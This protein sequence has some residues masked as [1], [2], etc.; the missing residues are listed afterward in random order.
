MP[1]DISHPFALRTVVGGHCATSR[2][3]SSN[4]SP[5]ARLAHTAAVDLNRLYYEL[6]EQRPG[7]FAT[8][9]RR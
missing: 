7:T 2:P 9:Y 3:A 4:I 6:L 8:P 1:A 5:M